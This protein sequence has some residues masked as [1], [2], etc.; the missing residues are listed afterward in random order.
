MQLKTAFK[1]AFLGLSLLGASIVNTLGANTTQSLHEAAKAGNTEAQY[2]L[3][4]QYDTG[5]G[6][7]QDFRQAAYWFSQ[8]A[9]KGHTGAQVDLA[10]LYMDGLGVPKNDKVAQDLLEHA[11]AKGSIE[12]E[13]LLESC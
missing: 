3:A 7:T 2:R 4:V 9:E 10:L 13:R 8:A 6:Q 5:A 11:A 12:A 1:C